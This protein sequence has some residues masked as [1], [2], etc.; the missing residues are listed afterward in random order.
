MVGP[1]D[2]ASFLRMNMRDGRTC[3]SAVKRI[4]HGPT[5]IVLFINSMKLRTC[6]FSPS[7]CF[8]VDRMK[9]WS[10]VCQSTAA[11]AEGRVAAWVVD[12]PFIGPTPAWSFRTAQIPRPGCQRRLCEGN[13][14]LTVRIYFS[15]L[16][17]P[18]SLLHE[19]KNDLT[20]WKL[21]HTKQPFFLFVHLNNWEWNFSYIYDNKS[22]ETS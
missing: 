2:L 14:D 20:K 8:Y 7:S 15:K 12:W 3:L 5:V 11:A 19:E 6:T 10:R 16:Q 22:H 13:M 1:D 9:R 18:L 17:D 4:S 21:F